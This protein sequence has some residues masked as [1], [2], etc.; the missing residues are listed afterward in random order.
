MTA[1]TNQTYCKLDC[2]PII[3]QTFNQI[4]RLDYSTGAKYFDCCGF[5]VEFLSKLFSDSCDIIHYCLIRKTSLETQRGWIIF[6]L[7]DFSRTIII[8]YFLEA[9]LEPP[10]Y[11]T[12]PELAAFTSDSTGYHKLRQLLINQVS[13]N[14]NES[15]KNFVTN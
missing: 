3:Q 9:I 4:V 2:F 5:K 12:P 14:L 1:E 6:K 15:L 13:T 11:K 8:L 10:K 7:S